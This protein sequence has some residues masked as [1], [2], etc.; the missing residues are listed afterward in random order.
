MAPEPSPRPEV[1]R[2]S[3]EH[4][5]ELK[6][7][8]RALLC[9]EREAGETRLKSAPP[10]I[11]IEPTNRCDATCPT[12]A[13][14]YYDPQK[15]LPGDFD[16]AL[17]GA[18]APALTFADTVLFGGYGEPLLGQTFADLFAFVKQHHC[19]TEL[20][21]SGR[22]LDDKNIAM[23]TAKRLDR[24]IFSVDGADD[25]T[26]IARRCVSLSEILDKVKAVK[27][28]GSN[29]LPEIAFNFTLSASNL[30]HLVPLLSIAA[31]AGVSAIHVAHQMIYTV[32]Q[33]NDSALSDPQKTSAVFD[34]AIL[35]A[36]KSGVELTLPALFGQTPC[37]Q[38]FELMMVDHTGAV[39]GCCSACFGGGQPKLLLGRIPEDALLALWNHP[40]MMQAR[41]A[42]YGKGQWPK[43]C[44]GCGFLSPTPK[45]HQ[46]IFH[47]GETT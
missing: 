40:L 23:L 31:E 1:I 45:A 24:L 4:G 16:K 25:K 13:R 3:G 8:N 44:M 33:Q 19:R 32:D 38:P 12:C 26:M 14:N 9:A 17:L 43:P 28:A 20:I 10:M 2:L 34:E 11:Q 47:K 18:L 21:T 35:I 37:R 6:N 39:Q 5:R 42:A 29:H 30:G 36:N 7:Q 27:N 46:R 22:H 15:N 41:A